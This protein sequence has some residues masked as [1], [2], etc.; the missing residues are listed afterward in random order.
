M[1]P[2]AIDYAAHGTLANPGQPWILPPQSCVSCNTGKQLNNCNPHASHNSKVPSL[3]PALA[4][5]LV[6][7]FLLSPSKP[8]PEVFLYPAMTQFNFSC[9][10]REGH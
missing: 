2:K 3:L 4:S 6:L 5:L 7:L 10:S 9:E 1:P 8:K